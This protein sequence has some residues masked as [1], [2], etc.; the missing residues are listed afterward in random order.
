MAGLTRPAPGAPSRVPFFASLAWIQR[1]GGRAKLA[2][3]VITITG[4]EVVTGVAWYGLR[5][6][7]PSFAVDAGLARVFCDGCEDDDD[8]PAVGLPWL[9]F[10]Y[11]AL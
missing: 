1:L 3:E 7:W 6:T 8:Q 2:L 5:F 9:A 11:R 10:T 4:D